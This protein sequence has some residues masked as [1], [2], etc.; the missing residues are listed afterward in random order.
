MSYNR[1]W[2][3]F[4]GGVGNG[5][6][7]RPKSLIPKN[8]FTLLLALYYFGYYVCNIIKHNN[9]MKTQQFIANAITAVVA[10]GL[11]ML[12]VYVWFTAAK[13]IL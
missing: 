11:T 4:G 13:Q 9:N 10:F 2:P 7:N 1:K 5:L 12:A 3:F 8:L 6:P